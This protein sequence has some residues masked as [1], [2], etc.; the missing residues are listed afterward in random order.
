MPVK[1]THYDLFA[2]IGGFSYAIDEV[3][4]KKNVKHIFVEI[5]QFCQAVLKKHWRDGEL[6]GDIREF[7]TYIEQTQKTQTIEENNLQI[8]TGGFPCQPF[9]T[10][11]HKKGTE[12]DRYLWSEMFRTIQLIRPQWVVA[13]NVYGILTTQGGL[14]FQQVWSDME[15]EGYEVQSFIIPAVSVNAP[16]RRNRVWIVAHT[17]S[18]G[19]EGKDHQRRQNSRHNRKNWDRDWKEVAFE[20]CVCELDDGLSRRMVQLSNGTKISVS[21]WR[22]ESLN[23]FGNAIVPQV[24]MKIFE[25]IKYTINI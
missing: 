10:A 12:D 3:F 17:C 14:A 13:E 6:Y 16:H 11:G 22:N 9:S 2:G 24:A 5:N 23:A 8:L 25:A 1:I 21:K 20:C 7:N 4:G 18:K 15:T 19:L